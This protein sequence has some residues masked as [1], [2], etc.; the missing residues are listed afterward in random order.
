M[1]VEETSAI[2][3]GPQDALVARVAM[4]PKAKV[5]WVEAQELSFLEV[6]ELNVL[7]DLADKA[8]ADAMPTPPK[9]PT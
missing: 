3:C 2:L 5:S 7:L 1:S 9:V 8:E 6:M 4:H